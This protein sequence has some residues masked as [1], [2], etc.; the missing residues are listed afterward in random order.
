MHTL[1]TFKSFVAG[2]IEEF[3]LHVAIKS[4]GESVPWNFGEILPD[5]EAMDTIKKMK[6]EDALLPS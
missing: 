6:T 2:K 4:V 5:E 1:H 3:A